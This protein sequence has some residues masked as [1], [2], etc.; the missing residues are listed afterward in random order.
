MTK[1]LLRPEAL[2]IALL[3]CTVFI[4]WW[5]NS[6]FLSALNLSSIMAFMPELGIIALGMTMLLTAGQFDLS[7]GAVFGF[8]PLL[9]YLLV[10]DKGWPFALAA[11]VGLLSGAG[12]GLANGILVAKV[13][14]SSFLV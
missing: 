8:A 2:P 4:F 11:L 7:V 12:I 5:L 9:T 14:I 1:L 6:A 10:N 3:A 13:G